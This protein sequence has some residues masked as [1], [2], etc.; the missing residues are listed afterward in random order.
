MCVYCLDWLTGAWSVYTFFSLG[1]HLMDSILA[2]LTVCGF[3]TSPLLF[4]TMHGVAEKKEKFLKWVYRFAESDTCCAT[5]CSCVAVLHPYRHILGLWQPDIGPYGGLLNVVVSSVF[6]NLICSKMR[7][8]WPQCT[9]CWSLVRVKCWSSTKQQQGAVLASIQRAIRFFEKCLSFRWTGSSSSAGCICRPMTL[10][11]R[12]PWEDGR[13]SVSTCGRPKRPL[14]S[15]CTDTKVPTKETFRYRAYYCT[16]WKLLCT[17]KNTWIWGYKL[18]QSGSSFNMCHIVL[19]L[20]WEEGW[21]LNKVQPDWSSPHAGGQ[22]GGGSKQALSEPC[23]LD[24]L[25]LKPTYDD[26]FNFY[27]NLL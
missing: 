7:N 27:V 6:L 25:I 15:V 1:L 21:V 19:F 26:N 2:K 17:P 8:E 14:W 3:W 18:I 23:W 5:L 11:W 9:V 22:T 16:A 10:V 20:D 12:T 4:L 13:S 24:L